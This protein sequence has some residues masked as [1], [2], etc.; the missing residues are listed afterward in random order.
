RRL[1]EAAML[2]HLVQRVGQ[3]QLCLPF[4]GIRIPEIL[5]YVRGSSGDRGRFSP[6][7]CHRAPRN[8]AGLV[9]VFAPPDP[10]PV[11]PSEYRTVAFSGTREARTP[12]SRIEPCTPLDRRSR[13]AIQRSRARRNQDPSTAWR[14]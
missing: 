3:S 11:S 6:P 9:S 2:H 8:L 7:F 12:P 4:I 1:G 14:S 13:R 10:R 5:E